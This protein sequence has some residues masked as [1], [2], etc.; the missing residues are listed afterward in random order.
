M[1]QKIGSRLLN[2]LYVSNHCVMT[3]MRGTGLKAKKA[4]RKGIVIKGTKAIKKEM[5]YVSV[6]FGSNE[7]GQG[8]KRL[9]TRVL[10]LLF[11]PDDLVLIENFD[12]NKLQVAHR[13]HNPG[14][15]N[16]MDHL[17]LCSEQYNMSQ[18]LCQYGSAASCPH[19]VKCIFVDTKGVPLRCLNN[20]KRLVCRHLPSCL[21]RRVTLLGFTNEDV[22]M[23][24][25]E[26]AQD[27]DDQI[28][29]LNEFMA[30]KF[31]NPYIDDEAVHIEVIEN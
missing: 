10:W 18:S 7:K 6:A 21:S 30:K 31:F 3:D 13:C 28:L 17:I 1:I 4:D 25:E 5:G 15:I 14:C 24:E 8:I 9:T 16:I 26:E 19:V 29:V 11:H 2:Q 23:D 20:P 12:A 27:P 22:I